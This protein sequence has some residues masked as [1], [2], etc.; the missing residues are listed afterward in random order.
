M[1]PNDPSN[2]KGPAE[3]DKNSKSTDEES[4]QMMFSL[5]VAKNDVLNL[6]TGKMEYVNASLLSN[7]QL[8]KKAEEFT[9]NLEL[10]KAVQ[11]YDEGLKRFPNDTIIMDAYTDVLLQLDEQKKAQQLIERSIQLNPNQEGRKYFNCAEMMEGQAA[12]QMFKKGIEVRRQDVERY[13]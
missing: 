13:R 7:I 8:I 9:E 3:E 1:N 10:E 4:H 11:L 2:K 5:G 6:K 12:V